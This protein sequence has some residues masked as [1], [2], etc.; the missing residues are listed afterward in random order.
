MAR[1]QQHTDVDLEPTNELVTVGKSE[2]DDDDGDNEPAVRVTPDG[3]VRSKRFDPVEQAEIDGD[4]RFEIMLDPESERGMKDR[5]PVWAHVDDVKTLRGKGGRVEKHGGGY[6]LAS[7]V[8]EDEGTDI[9][10]RDHVLMSFDKAAHDRREDL[11]RAANRKARASMI[12][13]QNNKEHTI[14][15]R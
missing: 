8:S 4:P 14:R 9:T 6:R 15:T 10:W 7:G 13:E 5:H 12:R 1:K 3:F 2:Q 11:E